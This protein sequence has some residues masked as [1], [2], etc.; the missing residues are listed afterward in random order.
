MEGGGH[1]KCFICNTMLVSFLCFFNLFPS[2]YVCLCIRF[3]LL[4]LFI[5]RFYFDASRCFD[6]S[7]YS[8]TL[9]V[10][11]FFLLIFFFF[12]SCAHITARTPTT[13]LLCLPFFLASRSFGNFSLPFLSPLSGICRLSFLPKYLDE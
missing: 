7:G 6:I 5:F 10:S 3:C 12:F 13:F 9:F 8:L 2:F 11:N 4:V 1:S